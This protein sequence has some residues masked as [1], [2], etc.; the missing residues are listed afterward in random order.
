MFLEK[1]V[2]EK[3]KIAC[4]VFL[5]FFFVL[6]KRHLATQPRKKFDFLV[7]ARFISLLSRTNNN[8]SRKLILYLL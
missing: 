3:C 4:M 7:I 2:S 6:G 1:E 5:H 8:K